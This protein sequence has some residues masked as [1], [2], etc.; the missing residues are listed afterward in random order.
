M[1]LWCHRGALPQTHQEMIS[2]IQPGNASCVWWGVC[3]CVC[4][5]ECACAHVCW[6]PGQDRKWILWAS[7]WASAGPGRGSSAS[8]SKHWTDWFES[9]TMQTFHL[10]LE[11]C[12]WVCLCFKWLSV[13]SQKEFSWE[14]AVASWLICR[15]QH[16]REMIVSESDD[17]S[18][19]CYHCCH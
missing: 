15:A 7:I 8:A 1:L 2:L 16:F 19:T 11:L 4:V 18:K 13:Q 9:K 14:K 6:S 3:V 17:V 5:C 12:V 10:W